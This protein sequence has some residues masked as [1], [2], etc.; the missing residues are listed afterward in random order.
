MELLLLGPHGA[1]DL[2]GQAQ[3]ALAQLL[4]EVGHARAVLG[5]V[6]EDA[7]A[8]VEVGGVERH[9]AAV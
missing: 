6:G 2:T 5:Q 3:E 8:G 1:R 7:Q 9:G 4:V